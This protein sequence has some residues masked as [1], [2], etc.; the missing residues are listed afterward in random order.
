MKNVIIF[1]FAIFASS[2]KPYSDQN[3]PA[4]EPQVE[5]LFVDVKKWRYESMD[6]DSVLINGTIP[7]INTRKVIEKKFKLSYS[8]GIK[9]FF[10]ADF[11]HISKFSDSYLL[12]NDNLVFEGINDKVILSSIYLGKDLYLDTPYGKL[13]K[14]SKFSELCKMFPESCK[15]TINHGIVRSSHIELRVS[16]KAYKEYMRWYLIF[17]WEELVQIKLIYFDGSKQLIA[18]WGQ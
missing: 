13:N 7:I 15:L 14:E 12:S 18:E 9:S 8:K 17:E 11:F 4:N 10:L 6:L 16:E 1:F 5:K 3:K 2:C